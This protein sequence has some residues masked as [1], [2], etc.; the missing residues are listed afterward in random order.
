MCQF[1]YREL[2]FL[3]H[4]RCLGEIEIEAED[5]ILTLNGNVISLSHKLLILEKDPVVQTDQIAVSTH[6]NIATL[7]GLVS[8]QEQKRRAESDTWCV[9]AV[10]KVINDIE[11]R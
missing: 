4:A 1:Y 2:N 9:F 7:S 10:D 8:T 3:L 11:V 6:D 5:G